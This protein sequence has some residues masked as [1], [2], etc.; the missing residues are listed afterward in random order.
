MTHS[1]LLLCSI[2]LPKSLLKKGSDMLNLELGNAGSIWREPEGENIDYS[3]VYVLQERVFP[4]LVLGPAGC[5]ADYHA[6]NGQ[7][8]A[9]AALITNSI[10]RFQGILSSKLHPSLEGRVRGQPVPL[11]IKGLLASLP[12]YF[13]KY[14]E[15]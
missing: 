2:G 1:P 6:D 5:Q 9:T 3:H 4:G 8:A 13:W 7:Y 14:I 12:A 10:V 15:I 11:E